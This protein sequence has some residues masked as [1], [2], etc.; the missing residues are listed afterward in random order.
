MWEMG[1]KKVHQGDGKTR[2]LL[3][4]PSGNS[5]P[6]SGSLSGEA[7][8]YL[9]RNDIEILASGPGNLKGNGT[10]EGAFAEMKKVIGPDMHIRKQ[11]ALLSDFWRLYKTCTRV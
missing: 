5:V 4:N 8:D 11:P 10:C 2:R 1:K 9:E 3:G 6:G 7:R